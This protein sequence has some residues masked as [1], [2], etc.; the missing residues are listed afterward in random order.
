MKYTI[1]FLL[2]VALLCFSIVTGR[3]ERPTELPSGTYY[4]SLEN[5]KN[6]PVHLTSKIQEQSA[7]ETD[8]VIEEINRDQP[9]RFGKFVGHT[10][11]MHSEGKLIAGTIVLSVTFDDR[12]ASNSI[13][14]FHLIGRLSN[15]SAKGEG[16]VFHDLSKRD[17]F[18][19]TLTNQPQD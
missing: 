11:E 1:A 8:I 19:W 2:T 16:A 10:D 18:K 5:F 14:T 12:R 7:S 6:I 13:I 9:P 3:A 15:H 17:E 4:L